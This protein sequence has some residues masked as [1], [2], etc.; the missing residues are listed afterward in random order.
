MNGALTFASYALPP[1]LAG[2]CGPDDAD[3]LARLT[4]PGISQ[5]L[6]RISQAFEGAWP[7]LELIASATGLDPLDQR[8]VEGYWLGANASHRVSVTRLG[9]DLSARFGARRGWAGI[10]ASLADRGGAATHAHHVFCVYPWVGLVRAGHIDP[11]L[12]ILDHCRIRAGTILS[13]GEG[14]ALVDTDRLYLAGDV[15]AVGARETL[16]AELSPLVRDARPGDPVTLH[17]GWV[18][19]RLDATTAKTRRDAE[20]AALARINSG[21]R[22]PGVW[23]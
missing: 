16:E 19:G 11:G 23:T 18:C 12:E 22:A 3:L 6:V 8:V 14:R 17:W 7:Y 1:N 10:A 21:A 9:N 4:E 20:G 2:Y 13:V 5:D 15:L